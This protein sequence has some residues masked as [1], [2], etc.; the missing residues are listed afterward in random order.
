MPIARLSMTRNVED[1]VRAGTLKE[2]IASATHIGT[3]KIDRKYIVP[4]GNKVSKAEQ[5]V[6]VYLQPGESLKPFMTDC[7]D[8]L[9]KRVRARPLGRQGL[10]L[11]PPL[12]LHLGCIP[13]LC[14]PINSHPN[15]IRWVSMQDSILCQIE[16]IRS[17]EEITTLGICL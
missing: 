2:I 5:E 11:C 4:T 10:V 8:K 13:I 15:L 16:I 17:G 14:S 9:G 7:A 12:H 1:T 3:F 6:L